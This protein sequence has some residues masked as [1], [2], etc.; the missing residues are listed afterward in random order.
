M[1]GPRRCVRLATALGLALT[2]F[3][4]VAPRVGAATPN[5][6]PPDQGPYDTDPNDQPVV[7]LQPN[8][9]Y[10]HHYGPI[11]G[12][13][14]IDPNVNGTVDPATCR[15]NQEATCNVIP[16]V[17]TKPPGFTKLDSYV[18]KI[19]VSWDP[20]Y[21]TTT[22]VG[23]DPYAEAD[24]L[25]LYLWLNPQGKATNDEEHDGNSDEPKAMYI[26]GASYQHYQLVVNHSG[27]GADQGGYDVTIQ[28]RY[29]PYI[30]P[31]ESLA[32]DVFP[33][34]NSGAFT[35]SV[36]PSAAPTTPSYVAP[37]ADA[38][39]L[40]SPTTPAA[41]GPSG[42]PQ[43]GDALPDASLANLS[44]DQADATLASAPNIFKRVA[45][46]KPP[47]PV[48][49]LAV[50]LAFGLVPLLIAGGGALWFVRRRPALL[51]T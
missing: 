26:D 34:D 30:P 12:Q 51:R 35:P 5:Q 39:S 2:A 8:G 22:G 49:G 14:Q 44:G 47:G 6:P 23:L 38:T 43:A 25:D 13:D 45:V 10:Q 27:Q 33:A 32:N 21:Q 41:T 50:V 24:E 11:L 18:A 37:A 7:N 36:T 20:G 1:T 42:L 29:S 4:H 31:G 16:I 9:V 40:A 28:T 3:L 19:T 17:F 46:Q 48:S 15:Q